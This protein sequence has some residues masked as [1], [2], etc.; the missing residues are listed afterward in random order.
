MG[1]YINP[2]NGMTKEE[3]CRDCGIEVTRQEVMD[4][5]YE[6]KEGMTS[7]YPN[8]VVNVLPVCIVD[9]YTFSAAGIMDTPREREA[10][11]QD[12]GRPR[13][14]FLIPIEIL[15]SKNSGLSGIHRS[16]L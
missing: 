12:D 13:M 11:T 16:K 10:F 15:K 14:Y 7:K 4:F 2:T 8:P 1:I 5:N 6:T 9:N 3:F